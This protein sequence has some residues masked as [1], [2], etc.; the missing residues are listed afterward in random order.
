MA[1]SHRLKDYFRRTVLG[2]KRAAS[3]P[4]VSG[5]YHVLDKTAPVIVVMPG[6]QPLA[7]HL[8]A[9]SVHGLCMVSSDCRSVS[10]IEKL[11]RNVE[12]NL[13]VHCI[14]LAGGDK[15]SYPAMEALSAIFG[16]GDEISE[17]AA[18][19]AHAVRGKLKSFDFAALEKRV[20]VVDMLDCAEVD[21]II[22]GI[23]KYG[24]E[25]IRP[26][27]GFI[28]QS[29]DT[30][31]GVQRVIAPTDMSHDIHPDKAGRFVIGTSDKLIVVEHYNSK[32]DLL[33]LVEGTTARD[34]CIILIRNGWISRLDHAAYLGREL[35]L[36]EQ[37]IRQGVPYEQPSAE[38][39]SADVLSAGAKK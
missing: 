8:A 15:R 7:D 24:A 5:P 10:D 35:T 28:V 27:A 31:L 32:G 9:L 37:A 14:I 33:R 36:A 39:T 2:Q 38:T 18:S 6:N 21:K 4:F 19:L 22:A 23:N 17:K 29:Y 25:G 20:Y 34:L 11:T 13:A 26:D 1:L 12:A 30:T 16:E 3:W